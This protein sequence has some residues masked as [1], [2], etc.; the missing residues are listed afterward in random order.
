MPTTKHPLKN[1]QNTTQ[2]RFQLLSHE[3]RHAQIPQRMETGV[4]EFDRVCGGGLVSGAV[5]LMGGDPGIGKS[6]LL[7][8]IACHLA[9]RYRCAYVSGE[10]AITQIYLRAD[11]LVLAESSVYFAIETDIRT[12]ISMIDRSDG[13]AVIIIDSIQTMHLDTLE[14]APGTVT[15]VRAC[16]QELIRITKQKN[17]VMV[18]VGHVTKDGSLAGPR[19][20]EHMVDTVLSFEGDSGHRFRILRAIKNRFGPTDEIGVFEMT[21]HGL[22]EVKDPS[23]LFLAEHR[24]DVAGTVVFAGV[25]GTRPILVEIQALIVPSPFST[26]RRAVVGW[27]SGRLAIVLA[28]LEARCDVSFRDK[29]VYLNVAGGLRIT[30]PAADL[31]VASALLSAL[32]DRATP[33]EIVVFG[34]IGLVGEVRA[35][36]RSDLRLREA[37]KRGFT[38][39]WL[40]TRHNETPTETTIERVDIDHVTDLVSFFIDLPE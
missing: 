11:R 9:R 28:V 6:T 19:V 27:D 18:M 14:S 33:P 23:A 10:E 34:E 7:F 38:Q 12:L 4:V 35:V 25:E 22:I 26:P 20:L 1:D 37:A 30:E 29:D 36:N 17:L 40:P 32:S 16:A 15:Q 21:D 24:D 3:N 8:Q 5:L 39:A 2:R 13:P 31:A